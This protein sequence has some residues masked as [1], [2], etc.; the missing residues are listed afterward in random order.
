MAYIYEKIIHGKPY[1][2]LRISKRKGSKIATK[3][4]A[5][6]GNEIQ[7]INAKI[8]KLP[9]KYKTEIRKGHKTIKRF[10]DTNYYLEKARAQKLKKDA[11]LEKATQDKIEAARLHFNAHF[12]KA[13]SKTILDTYKNFLIEFAYNTTSIEGNTITLKEAEKLLQE[14]L[15]PKERSPREIFDL[16]NTEKVFFYLIENKPEITPDLLITIHDM[17]MGNIDNRKGYRTHDIRVF[18]S[19]FNATP[20]RY[21]N[22]D[23]NLLFKWYENYKKK[24][25]P[26]VLASLF[27]QKLEKI[28]PFYDGNGRTGRMMMNYILIH[29]RYP[30]LIIQKRNRSE[31]LQALSKAD[32][33]NL[34]GVEPKY[35]KDLIGYLEAELEKSYWDNFN[36]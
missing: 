14:N 10:I 30:P 3:D 27:H 33:S 26:F 16:Q 4:I 12:L 34:N 7:K 8:N 36:I 20:G 19:H 25:H 35:F 31:Y 17:L 5:Y 1:Y 22:T 2:Y 29:H 23:M 6:L 28:H 24:L 9:A 18:R 32:R 11:Y 13:D 21:V 15:T